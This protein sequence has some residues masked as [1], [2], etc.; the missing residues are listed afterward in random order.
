MIPIP[1]WLFIGFIVTNIITILGF[2]L[3]INAT[4]LIYDKIKERKK[5]HDN[6]KNDKLR[7]P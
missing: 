4:I 1:Y 6:K 2:V 7:L 5:K 3:L